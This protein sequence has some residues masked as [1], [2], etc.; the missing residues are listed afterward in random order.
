MP[1]IW[2]S[3]PANGDCAASTDER[4]S[5]LVGLKMH[6]RPT[7]GRA[8]A[9]ARPVELYAARSQ[10]CRPRT[11]RRRHRQSLPAAAARRW[12]RSSGPAGRRCGSSRAARRQPRGSA[13]RRASRYGTSRSP[14]SARPRGHLHREQEPA[15]Y[16]VGDRLAHIPPFTGDGLAIAL[17]SAALAAEHIRHGRSPAALS[18]GGAAA[19]RQADP[20]AGAVRG[21]PPAA[22][23]G[24]C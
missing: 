2:C 19:D 16:R 7:R 11:G 6:L 10:L 1:A 14:W 20:V 18:G 22:P 21:S 9:L 15:V 4:D 8:R 3:P 23:A 17:G 12:S 13:R 5:S 24:R